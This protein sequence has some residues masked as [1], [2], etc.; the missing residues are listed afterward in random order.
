MSRAGSER[1]DT[2]DQTIT[3]TYRDLLDLVSLV[4]GSASTPFM[5]DHPTYVFPSDEIKEAIFEVVREHTGI[6][7]TDV[8]GYW[9]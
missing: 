9:T 5:R 3:L 8:R 1:V 2:G 7:P 4:A 6:E